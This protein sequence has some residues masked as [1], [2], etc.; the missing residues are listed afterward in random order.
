MTLEELV[1]SLNNEQ[2]KAFMGLDVGT[3]EENQEEFIND[4]MECVY[5]LAEVRGLL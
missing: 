3:Y 5:T 1:A 4:L 2:L